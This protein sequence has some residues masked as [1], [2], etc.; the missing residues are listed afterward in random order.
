MEDVG[1]GNHEGAL[2]DGLRNRL[3]S[4]STTIYPGE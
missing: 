4:T 2:N 1:R 3:V